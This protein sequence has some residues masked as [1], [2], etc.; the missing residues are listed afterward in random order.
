MI[1]IAAITLASDSA[2][3]LARFRPSKFCDRDPPTGNL[4]NSKFFKNSLKILNVYLGG[5][6]TFTFGER[7][8]TFEERTFTFGDNRG[9]WGF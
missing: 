8:F 7:T 3:T 5:E 9:S 2:M 6:S 1:R 4:K